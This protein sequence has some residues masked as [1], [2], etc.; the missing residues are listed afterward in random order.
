MN[1][2]AAAGSCQTSGV[3]RLAL[4]VFFASVALNAALAIYALLAGDF[5]ETEG[6]IL[7]TSL[8]VTGAVILALACEAARERGR[9]GPLPRIGAAAGAGGFALLVAGIWTEP[10]GNWLGQL[11]G[12]LLTVAGAVALLSLLALATLAPRFRWTFTVTAA[13][14]ALF[15]S[16]LVSGIWGEWESEWYW[17]WFGVV[18]VALAAF[19]IVVPALHRLSRR[20]LA[21]Q[22]EAEG[23]ARISFCPFCGRPVSAPSGIE[24][25]CESCGA[26]FTVTPRRELASAPPT[27][28][29]AS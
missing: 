12:S 3:R 8:S 14:A 13:L 11:A 17:R 2:T 16:L 1:Q 24:A 6:K 9:L 10:S 20:Q 28:S 18:A 25:T 23:A 22:P 4:R 29:A 26:A 15:G 27:A 21:A 5:G 7:F 19:A